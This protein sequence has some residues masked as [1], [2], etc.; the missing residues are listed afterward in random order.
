M[1]TV[2][3][4]NPNG[5]LGDDGHWHSFEA[6]TPYTETVNTYLVAAYYHYMTHTG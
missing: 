5:Y 3:A 2:P 4:V 6:E 1:E